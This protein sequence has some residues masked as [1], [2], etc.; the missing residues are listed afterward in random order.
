MLLQ[1]KIHLLLSKRKRKTPQ[2]R[3]LGLAREQPAKKIKNRTLKT[4]GCGTHGAG[5]NLG[6]V[7][8]LGDGRLITRTGASR[9]GLNL[10]FF[11]GAYGGFTVFAG[12]AS[13]WRLVE[14]E[15]R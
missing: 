8:A 10:H 2:R 5:A 4:G 15:V 1:G 11:V 7:P 12:A 9:Q 14:R 13:G 6:V 3:A